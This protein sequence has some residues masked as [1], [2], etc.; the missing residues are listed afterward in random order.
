MYKRWLEYKVKIISNVEMHEEIDPEKTKFTLIK[1]KFNE[2]YEISVIF[3]SFRK[4]LKVQI[5]FIGNFIEK[6]VG[7][8]VAD[9]VPL[10]CSTIFLQLAKPKPVEFCFVVYNGSKIFP[11]DSSGIP[12]PVSIKSISTKSS[13]LLHYLH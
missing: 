6:M 10:C 2:I 11:I 4:S 13:K 5:C 3:I 9:I 7:L 8:F 1:K 12:G